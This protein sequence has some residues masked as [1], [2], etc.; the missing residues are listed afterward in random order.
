MAGSGTTLKAAKQLERKYIG[1]EV[2]QEYVT[3]AIIE[4]I[5][6]SVTFPGF[7]NNNLL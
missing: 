5:N 4:L 6:K 3:K 7:N 1:F 2:S